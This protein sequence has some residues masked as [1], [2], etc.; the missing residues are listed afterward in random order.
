MNE[1]DTAQIETER[2]GKDRT[3]RQTKKRAREEFEKEYQME[4][5]RRQSDRHTVGQTGKEGKIE[6]E[7]KNDEYRDSTERNIERGK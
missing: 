6:R 7:R 1:K 4:T 2:G 3:D 5:D